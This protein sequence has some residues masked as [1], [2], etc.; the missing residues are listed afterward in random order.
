MQVAVDD[1]LAERARALHTRLGL[2]RTLAPAGGLAG[3]GAGGNTC[4]LALSLV[5]Q[6]A[7]GL[8]DL[9][10]AYS[11]TRPRTWRTPTPCTFHQV[12]C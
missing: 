10:H 6:H 7:A 8:T 12:L 1:L 3:D 5:R 4:S 9:F 11:H 2:A